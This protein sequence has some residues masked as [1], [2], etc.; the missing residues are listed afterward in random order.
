MG[1][2]NIRL[3]GLE[4]PQPDSPAK[5]PGIKRR[6]GAS[7]CSAHGISRVIRH[8]Q[9]FSPPDAVARGTSRGRR[10]THQDTARHL[11]GFRTEDRRPKAK[12]SIETSV[13]SVP[14]AT[15]RQQH[16]GRTS[17]ERWRWQQTRGAREAGPRP[18]DSGRVPH[19][20]SP[21]LPASPRAAAR[22]RGII[23]AEPQAPKPL[24]QG[25]RTGVQG[26]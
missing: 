25:R 20:T 16:S 6:A 4:F 2:K 7:R 21:P 13:D 23:P 26:R 15:M 12:Y 11:D 19:S 8:V 5:W 18:L 10:G 17:T 9:S 24:R 3:A 22:G 14:A 1:W